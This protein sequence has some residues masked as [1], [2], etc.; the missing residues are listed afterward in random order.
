MD[1]CNCS[2]RPVWNCDRERLGCHWDT[3]GWRRR[4]R[5]YTQIVKPFNILA[6]PSGERLTCWRRRVSHCDAHCWSGCRGLLSSSVNVEVSLPSE[7]I[8]IAV[9]AQD[10]DRPVAAD[11]L[12]LLDTTERYAG[13]VVWNCWYGTAFI[14][15]PCSIIDQHQ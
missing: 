10:E 1:R 4:L 5:V 7:R 11:H 6:R 12:T 13:G 14:L 15:I 2:L 9:V 3:P 8:A